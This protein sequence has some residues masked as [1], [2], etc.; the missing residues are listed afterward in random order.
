M[1]QLLL[2]QLALDLR[3]QAVLEIWLYVHVTMTA[4]L[5]IALAVHIVTV[6]L[7]W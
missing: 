7:Y 6:F 2:K 4:A 5:L 3:M 1:A